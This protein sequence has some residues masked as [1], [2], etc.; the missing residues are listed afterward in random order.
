E[1]SRRQGELSPFAARGHFPALSSLR[2]CLA[3]VNVCA[4]ALLLRYFYGP[5]NRN[6]RGFTRTV[7]H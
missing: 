3:G 7:M 2:R 1:L 5:L 6:L 4:F